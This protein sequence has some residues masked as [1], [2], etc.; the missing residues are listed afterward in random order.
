MSEQA[1]GLFL[2]GLSSAAYALTLGAFFEARSRARASPRTSARAPR[3]SVLKPLA[4]IDDELDANLESFAR[5]DYPSF[6]LLLGVA[7]EDDPAFRVATDFV[8]RH[9]RLEARVVVT[10]ASL[11]RNPKVAQLVALE[12]V[13]SGSLLVI[14]D[15]NVRVAGGIGVAG[16]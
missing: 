14:S 16:A 11:A 13:A 15:S 7:S 8:A 12:R 1:I 5:L 4:G 2:V 3:V 10:D 9:P 6:E